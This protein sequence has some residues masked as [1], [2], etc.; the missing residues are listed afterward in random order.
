MLLYQLT[1]HTWV[2]HKADRPSANIR[3]ILPLDIDLDLLEYRKQAI[4]IIFAT[5]TTS[6]EWLN[7][8]QHMTLRGTKGNLGKNE[9][10]IIR[11]LNHGVAQADESAVLKILN[12]VSTTKPNT[13]SHYV[14]AY[15]SMRQKVKPTYPK[16]IEMVKNTDAKY[17]IYTKMGDYS[18]PNFYA[19]ANPNQY[20][21]LP[22]KDLKDTSI[23]NPR[24]NDT[25]QV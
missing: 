9:G 8:L 3:S 12:S 6:P 16:G 2:S 14:D 7:V 13:G 15:I 21:P 20:D 1:R 5:V 24:D 19:A 11:L 23:I 10:D 18:S 22:F 25:Y 17:D 4:I